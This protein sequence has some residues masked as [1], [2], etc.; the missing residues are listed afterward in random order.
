MFF[1]LEMADGEQIAARLNMYGNYLEKPGKFKKAIRKLK[2]AV[3]T[4]G[5]KIIRIRPMPYEE[6]MAFMQENSENE[7][8]VIKF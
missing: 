3:Q 8:E 7:D 6:Y 4:D 2:R 5:H 1:M